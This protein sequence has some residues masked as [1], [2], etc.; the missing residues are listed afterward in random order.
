MTTFLKSTAEPIGCIA[1]YVI[2][3]ELQA[4]GS[5]HAHTLFWIKDAP[6]LGYSQEQDVNPLFTNMYHAHSL[7]MMKFSEIWLRTCKYINIHNHA[8]GKQA[9]DSNTLNHHLLPH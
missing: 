4:R 7:I 5:P 2:R 9:G 8:E 6:K 1:E 3:I